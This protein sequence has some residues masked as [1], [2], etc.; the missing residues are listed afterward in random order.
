MYIRRRRIGTTGRVLFCHSLERGVGVINNDNF[1]PK[2]ITPNKINSSTFE[3]ET[4]LSALLSTIP[5]SPTQPSCLQ[6][7]QLK[8]PFAF[9]CIALFNS[10]HWLIYHPSG[11]PHLPF[12][13]FMS[14]TCSIIAL[15][16]QNVCGGF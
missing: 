2:N 13:A 4:S 12:L 7:L 3:R 10:S 11:N 6:P 1:Y 9:S 15:S 14:S 8:K 5:K 16:C